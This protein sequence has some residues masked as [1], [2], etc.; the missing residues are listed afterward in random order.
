MKSKILK[1]TFLLS[2][3]LFLSTSC[4]KDCYE[5]Y[6]PPPQVFFK[7]VDADDGTNLI[8]NQTYKADSLRLYYANGTNLI[9]LDIFVYNYYNENIFNASGMSAVALNNSAG[10]TFYLK[11]N[12]QD[13][14]T[15]FV[16]IAA[17]TEECSTYHI[18]EE[19]KINGKT[20]EIDLSDRTF[21]IKK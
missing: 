9:L 4:L 11:L 20:P 7:I 10:Q 12:A 17:Q 3:V 8:N 21:L 19:L 15:I 2:A 13:T 14:D 18:L 1:H 16:K 6:T 5:N